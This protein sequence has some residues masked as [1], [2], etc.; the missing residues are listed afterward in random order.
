[1]KTKYSVAF[2]LVAFVLT[3]TSC[4]EITVTTQINRNGSFTRTV[5]VT[6]DST[7]IL[8][9]NLPY[10]VDASWKTEIKRDTADSKWKITYTRTFRNDAL[11][12]AE[13][14]SDTGWMKQLKRKVRI[15]KRFAFFYSYLTF[16]EKIEAANPFTKI[17]IQDSLTPG[18]M[19]CLENEGPPANPGDSTKMKEVEE[20][21]LLLVA[22]SMTEEVTEILEK[23]IRQLHD[24]ELP[25]QIARTYQDSLF[26]KISGNWNFKSS[27]DFIVALANW[28][29]KK[30]ILEIEKNAPDL[31]N[32]FDAKL[33]F[34][35]HVVTMRDYTQTVEM[36]GLITETNS[37]SLVGN[38]VKWKVDPTSYLLT[39][40]TMYAESRVVNYWMFVLTG[41][42][43]LSL[44]ILL[45][46]RA[47][48]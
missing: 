45:V 37:Q 12:N 43:V 1:M 42:V 35:N 5:T 19:K 27:R 23:G 2:L 4:R 25:P 33:A 20:K 47:Y 41:V 34:F 7:E 3:I 48:R 13:I 46:I 18:E 6:G 14:Q 8:N 22:R 11:L 39:D 17:R 44:I 9:K 24:P 21:A 16:Q 38:K 26:N 28:S 15:H 40:Y 30:K 29:G 32:A 31:F 10:P 36:P